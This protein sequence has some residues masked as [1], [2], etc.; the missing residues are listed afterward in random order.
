MSRPRSLPEFLNRLSKQSER[1][2]LTLDWIP[3]FPPLPP[4]VPSLLDKSVLHLNL[5][6]PLLLRRQ[7]FPPA[8]SSKISLY[9]KLEERKFNTMGLP[10]IIIRCCQVG[11]QRGRSHAMPPS[12]QKTPPATEDLHKVFCSVGSKTSPYWWHHLEPKTS[13]V[14]AT[15]SS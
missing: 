11:A 7:P 13:E 9:L 10:I 6:P 12:G 2:H 15:H 5:A 3:P 1:R 8:S 4:P 14:I